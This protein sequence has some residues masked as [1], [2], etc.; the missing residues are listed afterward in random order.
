M[1]NVRINHKVYEGWGEWVKMGVG[2]EGD[3]DSCI[4]MGSDESRFT[5]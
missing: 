5:V 1:L 3:Y 4:K 2:E